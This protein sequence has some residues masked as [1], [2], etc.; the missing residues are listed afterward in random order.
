MF[1]L[2]GKAALVTGGGRGLGQAIACGL[3]QCGASV[4]VTELPGSQADA[5]R[6]AESIRTGYGAA[7]L[8]LPLDITSQTSI[9]NAIVRFLEAF[10]RIDILINNA[11]TIVRKPSLD[12]TE[13]DW[14][15]VM[16]VNLKGAFFMS[17]AAAK[18][19]LMDRQGGKI[20]NIA[21]IN[22]VIGFHERAA[23]CASKAGL[24]N[25]TRVLAIDW[26]GCNI[27]VNA[28]GPSYLLTPLTET[29]FANDDFREDVIYRTPMRRIGTPK[30][31]VG[32]VAYLA[33]PASD[34]VTGQTLC[35]DGGW[36]A[37]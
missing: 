37:W 2:A 32:A 20:V 10:G 11:G 1:S 24:V 22:G 18:A 12:V 34:F 35:V 33:G 5:D 7:A 23:Y 3:A 17:Q 6:T 28:V 30:D 27:N 19:M 31:I 36:T 25:L 15:T 4:C 21:S 16:D 14:D 29:L 13:R 9:D 8:S 26:A